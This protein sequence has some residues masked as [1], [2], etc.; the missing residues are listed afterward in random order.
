VLRKPAG[1]SNEY[2]GLTCSDYTKDVFPGD[3]LK[4]APRRVLQVTR[5]VRGLAQKERDW[6]EE[7]ASVR[8]DWV[9]KV[10]H[11][12]NLYRQKIDQFRFNVYQPD[13]PNLFP[14][15]AELPPDPATAAAAAKQSG[16]IVKMSVLSKPVMSLEEAERKRLAD[17]AAAAEQKRAEQK[18]IDDLNRQKGKKADPQQDRLK[19]IFASLDAEKTAKAGRKKREKKPLGGHVFSL[20]YRNRHGN[21][22]EVEFEGKEVLKAQREADKLVHSQEFETVQQLDRIATSGEVDTSVIISAAASGSRPAEALKE[23]TSAQRDARERQEQSEAV[24][25]RR[26]AAAHKRWLQER[27][28][29]KELIRIAEREQATNPAVTARETGCYGSVTEE[30]DYTTMRSMIAASRGL[31]ELPTT[32][33]PP[34]KEKTVKLKKKGSKGKKKKKK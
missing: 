19:Q 32:K 29:Q 5:P 24:Y 31:K 34:K 7:A 11:Q 3:H 13:I 15:D 22:V 17:K 21:E 23:E 20:V 33:L 30:I 12:V 4:L 26:S 10:E 27:E 6:S 1:V 25:A 2:R 18:R 14:A 28:R 9:D 8:A 16:R